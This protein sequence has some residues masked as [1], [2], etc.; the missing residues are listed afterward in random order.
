M[1]DARQLIY[2]VAVSDCGSFSQ[3]A[4]RLRVAQPWLSRQVRNLENR[5]GFLLL[6]RTP[7]G[8]QL[9]ERGAKFIE[10]ARTAVR[11]LEAA[12]LLGRALGEQ[13][14]GVVRLGVAP[15]ALMVEARAVLCDRFV[16]HRPNMALEVDIGRGAHLLQTLRAGAMDACCMLEGPAAADLERRTLC[17]GQV[18]IVVPVDDPL[19][20]LEAIGPEHIADRSL[21]VFAREANSDVFAQVFGPL[22]DT[23][24]GVAEFSDYSFFRRLGERRLVTALPSWQPTPA[25]GVVRRAYAG[26]ASPLTLELVRVRARPN[27]A[28]DAFWGLAQDVAREARAA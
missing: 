17:T 20:R 9:T 19:A 26:E 16:S 13:S 10:Q 14:G 27:A 1:L 25:S 22:L 8:V 6:D 24:A 15:Y 3:A 18:D 2:F 28:L 4:T 21:A 11:E 5:L 12:T 7:R 23:V